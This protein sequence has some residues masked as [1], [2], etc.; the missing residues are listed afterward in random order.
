MYGL[1]LSP[2]PFIS[3]SKSFYIVLKFLLFFTGS[4]VSLVISDFKLKAKLSLVQPRNYCLVLSYLSDIFVCKITLIGT[5]LKFVLVSVSRVEITDY[6]LS[7]EIGCNKKTITGI[8]PFSKKRA[9][10]SICTASLL[11]LT[12][13]KSNAVTISLKIS[14]LS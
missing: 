10:V 4:S 8:I 11:S 14:P 2:F 7:V 1:S 9:N 12:K 3:Y 6:G 13:K 5:K